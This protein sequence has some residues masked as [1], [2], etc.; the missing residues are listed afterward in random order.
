MQYCLAHPCLFH[1]TIYNSDSSD[2]LFNLFLTSRQ[3]CTLSACIPSLTIIATL[4]W[5]IAF[6]PLGGADIEFGQNSFK[7]F[8]KKQLGHIPLVTEF[9]IKLQNMSSIKKKI[10]IQT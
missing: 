1:T 7:V 2:L 4:S 8:S 3:H 6:D 9:C 5:E 10:K